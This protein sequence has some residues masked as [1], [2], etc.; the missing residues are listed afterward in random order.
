MPRKFVIA[1]MMHETNTFSP[2]PTPI[3][4]FA[5]AGA[6][7]GDAAVREA[8]GTNTSLGGFIE[9]ARKAGADEVTERLHA[10]VRRAETKLALAR[11]GADVC[12]NYRSDEASAQALMA[13]QFARLGLRVD[14]FEVDESRLRD[15]PLSRGRPDPL[16]DLGDLFDGLPEDFGAIAGFSTALIAALSVSTSRIGLKGSMDVGGGTKINFRLETS[17]IESDGTVGDYGS[18]FGRQ[19]WAGFSGSWGEVRLGRQDSVPFQ[20]IRARS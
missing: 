4:S 20:T 7:S 16:P 1:M 3:E 5:R 15:H 6:L 10:R 8:E 9:V 18:F 19:M 14:E 11:A 13:Q 12:I 17:G 2:L